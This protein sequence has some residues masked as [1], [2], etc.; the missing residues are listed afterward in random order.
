MQQVIGIRADA[1]GEVGMG[2]IMRC[3][4]IAKQIKKLGHKTV[5]FTA[6]GYANDLLKRAGVESICLDSP[7]NRMET[8]T[9]RLLE[10]LGKVGCQKLLVDSYQATRAYFEKIRGIG[11]L[12]YMDDCFEDV[13]PVDMIINYNAYHVRFPYP[14]SY[15]GKAKLLLGTEYVPLREEFGREYPKKEREKAIFLSSGGGDVYDALGGILADIEK[16]GGFQEEVFHVIVGKFHPNRNRLEALAEKNPKIKLHYD[17]SNMAEWMGQCDA[18]VS[19]AGTVLFELC[20]M[21]IPTI[22]FVSADNQQYD[23]EFFAQE[24]R[25]LFAG[26]IRQGRAGCLSRITEGLENLIRD[27]AMRERMKKALRQVTDGQGA[28]RIAEAI[29]CL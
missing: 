19:A 28:V 4:T 22:F 6:D 12:I 20:A 1:N 7:W 27:E 29:V 13:Y 24:E 23:S 16:R 18:A 2:H 21:G 15:Q 10:E 25:M 5:F 17:V 3:I 26:D 11:K 8:E 9:D 14:E